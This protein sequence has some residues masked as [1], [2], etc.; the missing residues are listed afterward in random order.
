MNELTAEQLEWNRENTPHFRQAEADARA[1][2]RDE[3]RSRD[4]L[5]NFTSETE[6]EPTP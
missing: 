6:K 2:K 4:M 3:Q 1:A 5:R